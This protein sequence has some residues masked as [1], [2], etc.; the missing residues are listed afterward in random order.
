MGRTSISTSLMPQL[1]QAM[2]HTQRVVIFCFYTN[3]QKAMKIILK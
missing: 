3:K 2:P 1:S